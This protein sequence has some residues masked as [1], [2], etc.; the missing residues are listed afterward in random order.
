MAEDLSSTGSWF[1][2][3][4]FGTLSCVSSNGLLDEVGT[5]CCLDV[6]G[7]KDVSHFYRGI[8]L[9]GTKT[10]RHVFGVLKK[11]CHVNLAVFVCS[12]WQC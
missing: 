9:G 3:L 10:M 5:V 4:L 6:I 1:A 11:R 7:E 2:C 8:S 12:I